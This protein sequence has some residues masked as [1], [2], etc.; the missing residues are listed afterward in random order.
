LRPASPKKNK[1]A[2]A[3]ADPYHLFVCYIAPAR[4]IDRSIRQRGTHLG[5]HKQIKSRIWKKGSVG[6]KNIKKALSE[7]NG[8]SAEHAGGSPE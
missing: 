2:L 1:P 6:E 7:R 5:V 3:R 4:L 8:G